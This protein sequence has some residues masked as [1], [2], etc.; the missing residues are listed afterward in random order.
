L[1]PVRVA[2]LLKAGIVLRQWKVVRPGEAMN[3][4]KRAVWLAGLLVLAVAIGVAWSLTLA[5]EPNEPGQRPAVA[6][7]TADVMTDTAVERFEGVGRIRAEDWVT[8]STE[9][10]GRVVGIRVADGA[11]VTAGEILIELET[12]DEAVALDAA[13][14]ALATARAEYERDRK[15]YGQGHVAEERLENSRAAYDEAQ[16][17]VKA[18][19]VALENRRI[20]APFAGKVSLIPL[21]PGD[22]VQPGD[23]LFTLV[24]DQRLEVHVA[25]PASIAGTLELQAKLT[26][27]PRGV[28]PIETAISA[29]DAAANPSTNL[30]TVKAP[31]PVDRW[32]FNAG[33]TV[34]VSVVTN[35]REGALFVPEAAILLA[36]PLHYVFTVDGNNVAHRTPVEIGM[37]SNGRAE[38]RSG[39]Q[40]DDRVVVEG[41]QKV[42]DGVEVQPTA[43]DASTGRDQ[44]GKKP[45]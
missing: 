9:A 31:V 8:V 32:P 12:R 1:I 19:E 43:S 44:D 7:V 30:V 15:L 35:W 13:K 38:I 37:R 24:S 26:L 20:V 27:R 11:R 17:R 3:Q 14:A 18:A 5:E 33:Q 22:Y 6:V 28:D 2:E 40:A 41:M 42:R 34:P 4:K 25:V 45:S 29:K 39:L 21:A 10:A 16:A 36:G 23:P